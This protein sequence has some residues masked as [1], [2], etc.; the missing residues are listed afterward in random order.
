MLPFL[1]GGGMDKIWLVVSRR[2]DGYFAEKVKIKSTLDEAKFV[3]ELLLHSNS[4]K[5]EI[6]EDG[7]EY[8]GDFRVKPIYVCE[9]S[10]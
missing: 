2:R 8:M 7:K 6:Y 1:I 9:A 5:Y 3:G 4:V 10:K